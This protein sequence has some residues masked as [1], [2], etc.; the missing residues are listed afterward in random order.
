MKSS[1]PV[2]IEFSSSLY[3][4]RSSTLLFS[5]PK[6]T[7][8]SH[9]F[10][11]SP[12]ISG[13]GTKNKV[14][15]VQ[16]TI[17]NESRSTLE[18]RYSLQDETLTVEGMSR[19]IPSNKK[20]TLKIPEFYVSFDEFYNINF[21]VV[22]YKRPILFLPRYT[23]R[24]FAPK[25][26]SKIEY[27]TQ[28]REPRKEEKLSKYED[29]KGQSQGFNIRFWTPLGYRE[30]EGK[31]VKKKFRHHQCYFLVFSISKILNFTKAR[32]LEGDW[33]IFR[34][35]KNWIIFSAKCEKL[36][37]RIGGVK[38][39]PEKN[40]GLFKINFSVWGKLRSYPKKLKKKLYE[41]NT[42]I[43]ENFNQNYSYIALPHTSDD[44][45]LNSL[46]KIEQSFSPTFE[47]LKR[48]CYSTNDNYVSEEEKELLK[49]GCDIQEREGAD[50]II[51]PNLDFEQ[52]PKT[53]PRET[54]YHTSIR[55]Q[56]AIIPEC[57]KHPSILEFFLL[58]KVTLDYDVVNYK[59]DGLTLTKQTL[60]PGS[61]RVSRISP[62]D[63]EYQKE[64]DD[65]SIRLVNYSPLP[66][67]LIPG[68]SIT[69]NDK[70]L[71]QVH[72]PTSIDLN[73]PGLTSIATKAI[74]GANTQIMTQPGQ[75]GF[76]VTLNGEAEYDT[77]EIQVKGIKKGQLNDLDKFKFILLFST[78]RC[79]KTV[80]AHGTTT[81]KEYQE[82][83]FVRPENIQVGS[84]SKILGKETKI[85]FEWVAG[86]IY[87]EQAKIQIAQ[88]NFFEIHG[89]PKCSTNYGNGLYE[90]DCQVLGSSTIKMQ[91]L[92]YLETSVENEFN[93]ELGNV[94]NPYCNYE[95]FDFDLAVLG[96]NQE[97][98][99]Q[100]EE[101]V[102]RRIKF[103][104][105]IFEAVGTLTKEID[106]LIQI[107]R[108]ALRFTHAAPIAEGSFLV[109]ELPNEATYDEEK[110]SCKTN[111][112][113]Y[114][115]SG[116]AFDPGHYNPTLKFG[117]LR[118]R[119][120]GTSAVIIE[121]LQVDETPGARYTF[122]LSLKTQ[123][124]CQYGHGEITVAIPKDVE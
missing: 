98:I 49:I 60:R 7:D 89:A 45:S 118:R 67:P 6:Y 95:S 29:K 11:E 61:F 106:G 44:D 71:I 9:P 68:L 101:Q 107:Q 91:N 50:E 39:S 88:K 77:V 20:V 30:D 70:T 124:G 114:S 123:S 23:I 21:K 19:G 62:E 38:N 34:K 79:Q 54:P 108:F 74:S 85:S 18:C 66:S 31:K 33:E 84:T 3:I 32:V 4:S 121:N 93:V 78:S 75:H 100:F 94:Q 86:K 43:I 55:L 24:S 117:G 26:I 64:T 65:I 73:H 17:N 69:S 116:C 53:Q 104:E 5:F 48:I 36:S 57:L 46:E 56:G 12:L 40:K 96:E 42:F 2:F 110:S 25:L 76:L 115:E 10:V 83:N 8:G 16:C 15:D 35:A 14:Y 37:V 81:L 97:I 112:G 63:T 103:K 111:E 13:E 109:V 28:K 113:L 87:P 22:Q 72:I 82:E 80:I 99:E 120:E 27:F 119:E 1:W 41:A 51:V 102:K 47:D 122:K 52:T 105:D 92:N 90:R 58:N 59:G